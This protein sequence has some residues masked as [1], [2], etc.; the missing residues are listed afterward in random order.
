LSKICFGILNLVVKLKFIFILKFDMLSSLNLKKMNEYIFFVS[1][2]C[3]FLYVEQYF[4]L[5]LEL[6]HVM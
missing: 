4:K 1:L 2:M 6:E 5:T 3:H